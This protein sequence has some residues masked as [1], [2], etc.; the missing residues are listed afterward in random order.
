MRVFMRVVELA[1]FSA[2]ARQLGMSAAAVTRSVM[3]LE[4]H[5]NLRLLNRST[6]HLSLTDAGQLYMD[7]CREIIGQLDN[8]E[9]SLVRSTR[10]LN[11]TLRVSTSST[12]AVSGLCNLLAAYRNAHPRVTFDVTTSETPSALIEGGFDVGFT[13]V[14]HMPD[15]AL[16]SRQLRP[17][18]QIVVASPRYL[19]KHG[20]P[21]VPSELSS[22]YLLTASC[23]TSKAW[24]FTVDDEVLRIPAGSALQASNYATV[25]S[26]VLADMGIA[27]LPTPLVEEEVAKGY[28]LPILGQYEIADGQRQVSILYTGRNYLSARVRHFIDFVVEQY[29]PAFHQPVMREAA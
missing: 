27:I 19:Q 12:F 13:D 22:H 25:H 8:M 1:S 24:R 5:L 2:A 29:R 7:G 18:K 16:I 28:L 6:R 15:S 14:P 3:T 20:T 26:A 23:G 9:A 4:A 21:A 11:G 17:F 10:E